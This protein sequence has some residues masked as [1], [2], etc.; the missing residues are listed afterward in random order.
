MNMNYLYNQR[1]KIL[2]VGVN[3]ISGNNRTEISLWTEGAYVLRA[4][5]QSCVQDQPAGEGWRG[6]HL[7]GGNYPGF[8]MSKR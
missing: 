2:S 7:L 1:E 5:S 4:V 8:H 6:G 3:K